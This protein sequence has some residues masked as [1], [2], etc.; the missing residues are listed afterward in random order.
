MQT[1]AGKC[2]ACNARSLMVGTGGHVHCGSPACP[3]PTAAD[4]LLHEGLQA[5]RR[6]PRRWVRAEIDPDVRRVVTGQTHRTVWVRNEQVPD[7]W[8]PM[9][10]GRLLRYAS[11]TTAG[12][13]YSH[14]PVEELIDER[15]I[16]GHGPGGDQR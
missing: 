6:R 16:N 11:V 13:V 5:A 2:P 1:I 9:A 4:R 10:D 7:L 14:S 12:L 3:E 15:P 8:H